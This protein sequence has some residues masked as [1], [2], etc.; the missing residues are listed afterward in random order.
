MSVASPSVAARVIPLR[1]G[2][3]TVIHL[4]ASF[5]GPAA[6]LWDP[7]VQCKEAMSTPAPSRSHTRRLEATVSRCRSFGA[8]SSLVLEGSTSRQWKRSST[9]LRRAVSPDSGSQVVSNRYRETPLES[10]GSSGS[11]PSFDGNPAPS[12]PALRPSSRRCPTLSCP[13]SQIAWARQC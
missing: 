6:R 8:S 11:A 13:C 4:R 3:S 1:G 9:I 12:A 2:W 7:E 10:E 5:Q